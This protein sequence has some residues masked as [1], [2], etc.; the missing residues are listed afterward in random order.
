MAERA[1]AQGRKPR[2]VAPERRGYFYYG[3]VEQKR[4][5]EERAKASGRQVSS[6]I[7][8]TLLNASSEHALTEERVQRLTEEA[9]RWRQDYWTLRRDLDEAQRRLRETEQLNQQ[10]MLQLE[11][12]KEAQNEDHQLTFM[13][14]RALRVLLRA[15][16]EAGE[17]EPVLE[18][19]IIIDLEVADDPEFVKLLQRQL[20]EAAAANLLERVDVRGKT[21]YR[22][23]ADAGAAP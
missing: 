23:R 1:G 9:E 2:V 10:L 12:H 13:D 6:F 7:L 3:T 15:R 19:N 16:N 22:L 5:V 4:L 18:R 21:A 20:R 11:Q 17:F 14:A 8:Y